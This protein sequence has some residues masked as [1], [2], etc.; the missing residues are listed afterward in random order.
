MYNISLTF[1]MIQPQPGNKI[2][3]AGNKKS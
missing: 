2:Y 3:L 1:F